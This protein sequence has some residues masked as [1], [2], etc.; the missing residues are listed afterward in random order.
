MKLDGFIEAEEAA[1][2]SVKHACELF[3]VSRSAYYQRKTHTPSARALGDG[4]ALDAIRKVHAEPDGTYG[5]PRVHHE[6]LARQIFCGRR[7][8]RRLMRVGCLEGRCKKRWPKT[9]IQDPAAQAEP[10]DLIRRAFGPCTVLD[11]R[12]VGNITYLPTWEGWAY[13]ARVIDL[14]SRCVVGWAIADLMRTELISEAL[15]VAFAD[16]RPG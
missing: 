13:P 6:L 11:A 4:E 15:L 14:A 8:V 5:A 2:H 12:Y 3:E 16:R 1:A 7:R 10:L 9:T